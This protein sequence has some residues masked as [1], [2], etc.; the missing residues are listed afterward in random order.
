MRSNTVIVFLVVVVIGLASLAVALASM[1]NMVPGGDKPPNPSPFEHVMDSTEHW[2]FFESV[3]RVKSWEL[4]TLFGSHKIT[5]FMIPAEL[6]R[7]R[8]NA[9]V[10]IPTPAQASEV[11]PCLDIR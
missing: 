11:A 4:P 2:H 7:L 6:S 5:K 1:S 8:E 9:A 3:G 10:S